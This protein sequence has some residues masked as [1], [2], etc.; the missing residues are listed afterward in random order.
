MGKN[1]IKK[2]EYFNAETLGANDGCADVV[3]AAFAEA[4]FLSSCVLCQKKLHG[5]NV[6]MYRSYIVILR[7]ILSS[8]CW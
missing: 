7:I 5:L 3:I 1:L 8:S 4:D 6:F 2:R